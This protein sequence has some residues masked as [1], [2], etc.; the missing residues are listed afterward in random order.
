[1]I[2]F[3][4]FV[5]KHKENDKENIIDQFVML[6]SKY[7]KLIDKSDIWTDQ[8]ILTLIYKEHP[9]L[10]YKYSDGYGTILTEMY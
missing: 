7:L 8:V 9:D 3:H 10:F 2:G 6:Y 4:D 5:F 1:M